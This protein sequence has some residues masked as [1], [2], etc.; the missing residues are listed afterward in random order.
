MSWVSE[1]LGAA[2][3]PAVCHPPPHPLPTLR[4]PFCRLI[5]GADPATVSPLTSPLQTLQSPI[6]SHCATFRLFDCSLILET[7]PATVASR[8][9]MR[10]DGDG[11]PLSVDAAANVRPAGR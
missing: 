3:S 9:T 8:V 11:S 5:L 6:L 10:Q 2:C 7:D 1:G 4:H